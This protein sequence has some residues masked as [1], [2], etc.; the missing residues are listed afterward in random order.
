MIE[1]QVEVA[2]GAS[3]VEWFSEEAKRIYGDVIPFTAKG[4]RVLVTKEPVGVAA[5]VTPWNFPLAMV[6]RKASAAL[7]A[8]CAC[9]IK[10]SD[11]TPLTALALAD[12]SIQ[13]SV[14]HTFHNAYTNMF[15][16]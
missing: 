6:L 12:V 1:S 2:H 5:L 13:V 11:E 7:A 3:Y 14:W 10:P 16:L 4:R 8:G 15:G 9:V